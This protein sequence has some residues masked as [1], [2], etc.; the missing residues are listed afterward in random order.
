MAIYRAQGGRRTALLATAALIAGLVAGLAIGRALAPGLEAQLVE[1][2]TKAAPIASSLEVVRT[3]YPKLLAGGADPGGAEA[4]MARAR[5]TFAEVRTS[6]G[7]LDRVATAEL[8]GALDTLGG[9]IEARAPEAEV[10]GAIDTAEGAL[11][12]AL[13]AP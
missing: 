2:R 1:L 9:L 12:A 10:A 7:A 13:P 3:E 6:F 4:A 11:G 8:S 5:T